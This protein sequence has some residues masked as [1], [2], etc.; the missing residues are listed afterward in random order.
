MYTCSVGS[1]LVT[2]ITAH[3]RQHSPQNLSACCTSCSVELHD[4]TLPSL[5]RR[6]E[7]SI[8]KLS[9]TVCV[10]FGKRSKAA[11]GGVAREKHADN[12]PGFPRLARIIN[13]F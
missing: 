4:S 11:A 1:A 3:L 13:C 9:I 8:T 12:L 10:A 2:F 6:N 5:I 7:R